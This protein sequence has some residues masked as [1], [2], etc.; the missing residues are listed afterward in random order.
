M[1]MCSDVVWVCMV[2]K[3]IQYGE[4]LRKTPID[5]AAIEA[6]D[7][8]IQPVLLKH[9]SGHFPKLFMQKVVGIIHTKKNFNLPKAQLEQ[10]KAGRS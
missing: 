6:N 7:A 1:G 10:Y 9:P 5:N 8:W 4:N 3:D 2:V